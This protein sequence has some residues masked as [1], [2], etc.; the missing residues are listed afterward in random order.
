M[1]TGRPDSD[2]SGKHNHDGV[3]NNFG[4]VGTGESKEQCTMLVQMKVKNTEK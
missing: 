1:S 4:V 2:G 3:H